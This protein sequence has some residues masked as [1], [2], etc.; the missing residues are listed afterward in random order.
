MGRS[1]GGGGGRPRRG[2]GETPSQERARARRQQQASARRI[3]D[4][5][6]RRQDA[7]DARNQRARAPSSLNPQR[8][9][10]EAE[11]AEKR[12]NDAIKKSERSINRINFRF[13]S[14]P[15]MIAVANRIKAIPST[16][17]I[18]T[19]IDRERQVESYFSM[20]AE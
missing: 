4:L 18:N 15:E 8:T 14:D 17:N 20:F 6:A 16:T 19:A 3:T 7:T 1:K 10:R 11:A 12:V 5:E 2:S 9:L 13:A